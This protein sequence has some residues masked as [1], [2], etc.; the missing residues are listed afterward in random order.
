MKKAPQQFAVEDLRQDWPETV[1]HN[2]SASEHQRVLQRPP[3]PHAAQGL[4]A[5]AKLA[6]RVFTGK[7]D[8]LVWRGQ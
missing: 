2:D 3:A 6:W 1:F 5:R 7:A 8:A 4:R